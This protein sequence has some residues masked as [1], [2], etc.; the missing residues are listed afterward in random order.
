MNAG[1]V[2]RALR[3]EVGR[4]TASTEASSLGRRRRSSHDEGDAGSAEREPAPAR[5]YPEPAR[6]LRDLQT[7]HTRSRC[8]DGSGRG[9]PPLP[10]D[11]CDRLLRPRISDE[12]CEF[13][14]RSRGHLKKQRFTPVGPIPSE[15]CL[16]GDAS[17]AIHASYFGW[18][19]YPAAT[20]RQTERTTPIYDLSPK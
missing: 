11:R 3:N 9:K 13:A 18:C 1:L 19:P 12:S 7:R 10:R 15:S 14:G 4:E 17:G 20:C 6:R 16:A 2:K 8:I 5:P